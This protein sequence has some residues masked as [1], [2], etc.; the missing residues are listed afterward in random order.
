MKRTQ[1]LRMKYVS[2]FVEWNLS[3]RRNAHEHATFVNPS[4]SAC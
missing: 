4:N 2:K 1:N 3:D